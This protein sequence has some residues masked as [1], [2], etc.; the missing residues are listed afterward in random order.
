MNFLGLGQN[1]TIEIVLD[2]LESRKL[3]EV[4]TDE[5][6][7]TLL[8][9]FYNGESLSGKVTISVKRNGKLE[10][11]G[12]KIDFVGQ[13]DF[14]A[15]RGSRDEFLTRTQELA[16]PGIL[17]QSATYPFHFADVE[18]PYESYV[19]SN[20]QLRYF[21]RV[22][23][24]RRFMDITKEMEIVVH[25]F[26]RLPQPDTNIQM[27]V[28][29]EE[30]LHIE[31]EYN[32]SCYHLEDVIVGKIYFLLVRVKIKYMEIQILRREATGIGVNQFS[33]Q[34][35]LAKFEIMDGAP[36]RGE[37]IPIRLFLAAYNLTPTMRD[38]N[39]KFTVRYYLNL[40][41]L[42]EEERR[43][44]KQH[45]II[46]YRK[47]D[48]RPEPI[49]AGALANAAITK[50]AVIAGDPQSNVSR[51]EEEPELPQSPPPPSSPVRNSFLPND[52]EDGCTSH[53]CADDDQA[54]DAHVKEPVYSEFEDRKKSAN[55]FAAPPPH[56]P[57]AVPAANGDAAVDDV[58]PTTYATTN[59]DDETDV[60]RGLG[61]DDEHS[62]ASSTAS[63]SRAQRS[64]ARY[65][66]AKERPPSHQQLL[67][68]TASQ[69]TEK[70]VLETATAGA[71]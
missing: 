51:T 34:E 14:F 48:K 42:D 61:G 45:E 49:V 52:E 7:R 46:L 54:R 60:F 50:G 65:E 58:P 16:R 26:F 23:I 38:V 36:V 4:K 15:D 19:G 47:P 1:A 44:Y 33:D 62:E 31:F 39:R 55:S 25:S 3:V 20:V 40:V 70:E 8:P 59:K 64:M 10:Y 68:P 28:G 71:L 41:L 18:K 2:S 56:L 9:V 37:S 22:T 43:Y 5:N 32:K 21:L 53:E 6:N 69:E 12:I 27:E 35:T 11:Q 67:S 63:M 13:I 57:S 66:P 30:S 29:I 17:S 24:V